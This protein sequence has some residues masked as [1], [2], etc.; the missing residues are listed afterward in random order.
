MR[1]ALLY[2]YYVKKKGLEHKY[3]LIQEGEKIKFLYLKTPN[4]IGENI[5]AFFQQ[6]PKEFN[7]EKYVDYSTQF[8]KSFLE[9]LKTVLECIDWQYE[10]RGSLTSFFS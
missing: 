6:L 2:N 9:P 4:P 8:E 3:P 5:I 10:R 1:G 7:L